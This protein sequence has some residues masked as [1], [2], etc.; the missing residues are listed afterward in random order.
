MIRATKAED[1]RGR[2]LFIAHE[3]AITR[4]ESPK[5]IA[6]ASVLACSPQLT[7]VA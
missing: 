4:A 3:L 1:I 6:C 7:K 2:V 5:S